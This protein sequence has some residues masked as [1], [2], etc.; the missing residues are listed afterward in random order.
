ME[1]SIFLLPEEYTVKIYEKVKD[2][3]YIILQYCYFSHKIN[4]LNF[5]LAIIKSEK[6][7]G[8]EKLQTL[9]SHLVKVDV[10]FDTA[11]SDYSK[12]INIFVIPH[13]IKHN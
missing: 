7:D 10:I 11:Y 13:H 12:Q 1:N 4:C 9:T 5:F 8:L 2:S 6:V 3:P